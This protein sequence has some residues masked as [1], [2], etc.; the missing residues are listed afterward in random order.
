[1]LPFEAPTIF[2]QLPKHFFCVPKVVP[3]QKGK[4]ESEE[5]FRRLSRE[6]EIRFAGYKDKPEPERRTRCKN[7][8][9]EGQLDLV[10]VP[11]GTNLQLVFSSCVSADYCDFDK[12]G[13][14]VH[15]KSSFIMNGVCVY[16]KG[17]LDLDKLEGIASLEYDVERGAIEDAH[18][19]EL[20][21]R[22]K[23][24]FKQTQSIEK[25]IIH[26]PRIIHDTVIKPEQTE[27]HPQHHHPPPPSPSSSSSSQI[28]QQLPPP[29]PPLS[30]P[31]HIPMH[32]HVHHPHPIHHQL[33]H[34]HHGT[35]VSSAAKNERWKPPVCIAIK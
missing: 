34:L 15:F 33:H 19:R 21:D 5:I 13:K 4:F 10:F 7:A 22:W 31:Q 28:Q 9:N 20:V 12:D 29:S 24:Y 27:T 1:M 30:P 17:W 25:T 32:H 14:K 11:T 2:E 8:C 23:S 16:C 35:D 3:D 6:S 18:R 26:T